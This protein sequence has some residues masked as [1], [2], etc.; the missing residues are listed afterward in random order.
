MLSYTKLNLLK[1]GF[2]VKIDCIYFT[3]LLLTYVENNTGLVSK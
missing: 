1:M 3:I 2:C